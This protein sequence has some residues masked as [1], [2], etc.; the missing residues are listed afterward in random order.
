MTKTYYPACEWDADPIPAADA[1]FW[2]VGDRWCAVVRSNEPD[3]WLDCDEERPDP[4]ELPIGQLPTYGTL[5]Y[6]DGDW[7]EIEEPVAT[8]S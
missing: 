6:H 2:Q 3:W 5:V 8:E 4:C 1:W 7:N